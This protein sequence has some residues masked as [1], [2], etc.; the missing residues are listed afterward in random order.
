LGLLGSGALLVTL[1]PSEVPALQNALVELGT[2]GWEIG[3][4]ID[5]EEGMQMIGYEGEVPLPEFPRD[6]LARYFSS[7][8]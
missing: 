6:E 4:M 5:P 2:D 7:L 8:A 3:M 1:P